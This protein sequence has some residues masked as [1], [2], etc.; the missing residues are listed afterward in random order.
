MGSNMSVELSGGMSI[1]AIVTIAMG[2]ACVAYIALPKTPKGK[3]PFE[4]DTREEVRPFV[5]DQRARDSVLKNGYTAKKL[6]E[7]GGEFDAIMIGS[8]IGGLVAA[9]LLARAGKRV[10]VLEQHDQVG[11][12]C[13]SFHE[14]GF[15]FDTGIHYIGEMRNNTA[16]RFLMDQISDGQLI[17]ADV[18]DDFDT[19]VLVDDDG[20]HAG[21]IRRVEEAVSSGEILKSKWVRIMH[22]T[23]YVFIFSADSFPEW[24]RRHCEEPPRR[25]PRRRESNQQILRAH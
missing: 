3:N 1:P 5:F 16:F 13:H 8:G 25:F 22:L 24:P 23:H 14:K 2:V 21:G 6:K 11:G 12:C 7:A 19:V 17:W 10:L 4:L 18:C 9:A 15:E 20:D